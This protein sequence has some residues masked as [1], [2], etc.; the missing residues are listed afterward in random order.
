[1]TWTVTIREVAEPDIRSALAWYESEAPEQAERFTQEFLA[2]LDRISAHPQVVAS[3]ARETRRMQLRIFPFQVWYLTDP[4]LRLAT[5][6]AVVH[7][8]QDRERFVERR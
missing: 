8:R 7:D 2:T 4:E 6:I 1:M 5:V 3:F